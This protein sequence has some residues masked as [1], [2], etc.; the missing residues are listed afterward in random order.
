MLRMRAFLTLIFAMACV[1]PAAR[2]EMWSL[3]LPETGFMPSYARASFVSRMH[4]RHGGSHMGVQEYT[5]HVPFND[6]R[7]SRAGSWLFY[8]Q[9]TATITLMDVGGNLDL[10]KDELMLFALPVT[11]IRPINENERFM[12]SVI[13]CYAGDGLDSARAWDM[14]MMLDYHVKQSET[15]SYSLGLA[16]SPRF[17]SYVVAPYISFAWQATP[18]WLVRMKG[19]QLTGLYS[20]TNHL[21]VGSSFS[22]EGGTWMVQT[23]DKQMVFRTRMFAASLVAEYD[24]PQIAGSKGLL[25]ASVGTT[26]ASTAEFCKRG[27]RKKHEVTYHYQPGV[28]VSLGADYRF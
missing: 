18:D 21:R 8:M 7:Q 24:L 1:W 28:V 27:L 13:P 9:G 15:F 19:F 14:A 25:V 5:L 20:V 26:V 3:R 22:I 4:E 23:Q 17:A 10:Q 12:I 16:A 6:P 11:L 2:G